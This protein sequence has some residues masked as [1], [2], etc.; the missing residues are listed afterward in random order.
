[1]TR[2]FP[3]VGRKGIDMRGGGVQVERPGVGVNQARDHAVG[4]KGIILRR[5][6]AGDEVA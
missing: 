2:R 4:G 6:L 1:M 3:Q 5:W